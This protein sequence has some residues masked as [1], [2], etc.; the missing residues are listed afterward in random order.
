MIERVRLYSWIVFRVFATLA[1]F[2]FSDLIDPPR[3]CLKLLLS[4][5]RCNNYAQWASFYCLTLYIDDVDDAYMTS[6]SS[7]DADG[8]P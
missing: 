6:C 3:V 4:I 2:S 5:A 1:F 8:I 7:F